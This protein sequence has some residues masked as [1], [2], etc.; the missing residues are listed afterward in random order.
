[1]KNKNIIILLNIGLLL[2]TIIFQLFIIE[3]LL[4]YNEL[5]SAAFMLIVLAITIYLLNFKRDNKTKLKNEILYK[6]IFLVIIFFAITYMAGFL[7]G[8]YKNAYSLRPIMILNNTFPIIFL[9]VSVEI[10]RYITINSV[11]SRSKLIQ[12]TTYTL[13]LFE[14][15][16]T[17]KVSR[18][19]NLVSAFKILTMQ[20]I[21]IV[22]KNIVMT[23][24]SKNGGL[25]PPLFYRLIMDT[26]IYLVPIV[27]A[28][29][30]YISSI[31][32]MCFPLIL[33]ISVLS[34]INENEGVYKTRTFKDDFSFANVLIMSFVVCFVALISG[35]FPLTIMGIGSDSMNPEIYKGDAIIYKKIKNDDNIKIGD[36]LVFKDKSSDRVIVHRLVEK[37]QKDNK[38]YY[39]TRGDNNN[40]VDNLDLV[41][42]D[43]KG[44]VI[45]KVKYLA[46]PSV[47]F[48][49]LMRNRRS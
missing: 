2:Y 10:Y 28:F 46:L 9:V 37:N 41:I 34:D 33:Y 24:L 4:K 31:L 20:I 25:K 35:F 21:P 12:F 17:V 19:F 30:E 23:S 45:L 26:Y 1:M 44:V 3:K 5:I 38:L 18:L 13:T 27:P 29:S 36:I 14:V 48:N 22:T 6:T 11:N 15:F 43:I 7:T 40:T 16:I 8:F 47:Y 42:D 39:I 49:E 32:G